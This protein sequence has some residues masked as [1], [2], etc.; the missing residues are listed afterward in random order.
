MSTRIGFR[1]ATAVALA[2]VVTAVGVVAPTP[3]L[4]AEDPGGLTPQYAT[5][6]EI[7]AMAQADGRQVLTL[8]AGSNS[9]GMQDIICYPA[10]THPYGNNQPGSVIYVNASVYCDNWMD[11]IS[12]R[13]QIYRSNSL[14]ASQLYA[15][16]YTNL[17]AG[18]ATTSCVPGTYFSAI[19]AVAARYDHYPPVIQTTLRLP[20][21]NFSCTSPPRP[22]G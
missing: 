13:P 4:A 1:A 10:F 22:W 11:A 20:D 9:F 12:V 6:E 7:R 16:V 19:T 8:K 18:N 21:V 17:V 15:V 2:L 5:T 14:V 3:A